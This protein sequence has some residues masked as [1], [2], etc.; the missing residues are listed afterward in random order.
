[1]QAELA[2]RGDAE[3][4]LSA[5]L[6]LLQQKREQTVADNEALHNWKE[7]RER[8]DAQ[9][10]V[11]S[12]FN[13]IVVLLVLRTVLFDVVRGGV[14]VLVYVVGPQLQG[15][16]HELCCDLPARAPHGVVDGGA[17]GGAGQAGTRRARAR[18]GQRAG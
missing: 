11:R 2:R 4:R 17:P 5:A 8:N 1:M 6:T 13:V 16:H 15:Q 12:C 10:V 14:G 18:G 9:I 3:A 7:R